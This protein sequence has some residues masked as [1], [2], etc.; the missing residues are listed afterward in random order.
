VEERL[1][2]YEEGVAPTK[3]LAAMQVLHLHSAGPHAAADTPVE[4][5][6][7]SVCTAYA[8][9]HVSLALRQLQGTAQQCA[10]TTHITLHTMPRIE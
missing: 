6:S 2:F 7:S 8:R 5:S 4:R 9:L 1:R 3:N 10:S